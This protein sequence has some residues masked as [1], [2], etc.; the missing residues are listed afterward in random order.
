MVVCELP[1]SSAPFFWYS[2]VGGS[3]DD[4]ASVERLGG[5]P[6]DELAP[7]LLEELL[8]LD[9]AGEGAAIA[10]GGSVSNLSDAIFALSFRRAASQISAE[11][12]MLGHVQLCVR[13]P[14]I[15][16]H[17]ES[18]QQKHETDQREAHVLIEASCLRAVNLAGPAYKAVSI[19]SCADP[20]SATHLQPP[21]TGSSPRAKPTCPSET[22]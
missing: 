6:F 17:T 11:S 21:H 19:R 12:C 16:L 22:A 20:S 2:G 13:R 14:S 8:T 18:I 10:S 7:S 5:T 4:E 9:L 3:P 1:G 15:K